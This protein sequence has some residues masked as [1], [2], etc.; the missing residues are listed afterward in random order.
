MRCHIVN[1]NDESRKATRMLQNQMYPLN[2]LFNDKEMEDL[3]SISFL[4]HGLQDKEDIDIFLLSSSLDLAFLVKSD[5]ELSLMFTMTA[6]SIRRHLLGR[7][8]RLIMYWLNRRFSIQ[9]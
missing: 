7:Y 1:F 5:Q 2:K 4:M 3:F 8:F 6:V 9:I